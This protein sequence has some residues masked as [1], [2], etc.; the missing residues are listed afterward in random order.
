MRESCMKKNKLI[1]VI[2]P[3]YQ[4][5]LYVR[6]CLDS[7]IEQEYENL[8]IILIDDGSTDGSSQICDDYKSKDKRIKVIH[9]E[10]GGLSSA[11]NAGIDIANGEYI[12]FIDSDDWVD[13]KYIEKLYSV[14]EIYDCDIAQCS[15]ENVINEDDFIWKD[16]TGGNKQPM[17]YTGRE[18]SY[19]TYRLLSWECNLVWNKLY[20]K[21][22][23]EDIR[24]PVGKIHEDEFTTYKLVWKSDKVGVISDQLYYY[25]YRIGSIM[26]QS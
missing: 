3:V 19:A 13:P 22:L 8:E 17:L 26:Q 7:I 20:K 23:F 12:A 1:S 18:F 4:V 21:S 25:R 10:N 9:R 24:F 6:K 14:C 2:V 11:R 16:K 5:E 15:Y